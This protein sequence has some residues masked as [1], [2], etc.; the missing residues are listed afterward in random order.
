MYW[1]RPGKARNAVCGVLVKVSSETMRILLIA[2]KSNYPSTSPSRDHIAQGFPCLAATLKACGQEVFGLNMS[3]EWCR[4]SAQMTL[5]RSLKKTIA[6]CRPH[7]I[8]LGGLSADYL[9]VRDAISMVRKIAP[10]I[11][12]ICG[13]GLVSSDTEYI[14]QVLHPDF[15]VIGEGEETVVELVECIESGGNLES[16]AGIAYWKDGEPVYTPK[17][18]PIPELDKLPFPDYS[19]FETET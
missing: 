4:I 16:V 13:G 9:F 14:L 11:L 6:M 7:I 5:C 15:A 8:G 12:I 1:P 19:P 2:P 18:R 3:Y 17:R 10:D